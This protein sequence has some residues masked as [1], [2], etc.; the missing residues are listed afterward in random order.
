MPFSPLC[1]AVNKP[2]RKPAMR[3]MLVRWTTH[4][5]EDGEAI[6]TALR[7]QGEKKASERRRALRFFTSKEIW[8]RR[9]RGE[10]AAAVGYVDLL[11][12]A[13][14]KKV[15]YKLTGETVGSGNKWLLQSLTFRRCCCCCGGCTRCF[16]RNL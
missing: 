15:Y 13:R 7:Q 14:R 10:G 5:E 9:G 8:N 11:D 3:T 16:H 4:E 2:K 12:N 1:A 6:V